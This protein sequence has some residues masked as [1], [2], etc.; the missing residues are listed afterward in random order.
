MSGS[1][2]SRRTARRTALWHDPAM[3]PDYSQVVELDLVHGRAL[4]RR[5]A[6]A[7]GPCAA[8]RREAVA[9]SSCSRA[10][11]STTATG[12][13]RPS[14]SPSP[15]AI[16]PRRRSGARAA[17][18]AQVPVTRRR[19]AEQ[20]PTASTSDGEEFELEHG[21]VVI[22]AITSCTNTSNPPGDDRRRPAREERGRARHAPQAVGQVEPRA[23]ARRSSRSTTTRRASRSTSTSSASRRSAT[24]ARRASGTRA[25][26]PRRSRG[27]RGG[28]PRRLLR[29]L[30][31]TAT[32]RRASIRR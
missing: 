9:S 26:C 17:T 3:Q 5:A 29:A 20:A 2:W 18:R 28:R 21:A 27:N 32:S 8:A 24:A 6:A 11:A 12:T 14:R 19:V 25:R 22:A 16:R 13:T 15:P 10:S 4:A 23:R 30:R 7:A 1:R 31:A